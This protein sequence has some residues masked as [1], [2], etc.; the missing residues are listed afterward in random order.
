M[1]RRL[2]VTQTVA[3]NDEY[4]RAIRLHYGQDGLATDEEVRN[5]IIRYGSSGDDDLMHDL[6]NHDAWLKGEA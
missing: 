2:R 3:V 1:R 5:W 4:R 6:A